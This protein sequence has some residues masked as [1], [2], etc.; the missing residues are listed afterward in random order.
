VGAVGEQDPAQLLQAEPV[1]AGVGDGE[2]FVRGSVV[3]LRRCGVAQ[4]LV[5]RAKAVVLASGVPNVGTQAGDHGF[6][7][8]ST[9]SAGH[10]EQP[11]R[12]T[13]AHGAA[14]VNRTLR[15]ASFAPRSSA[16]KYQ[17]P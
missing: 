3:D 15:Q 9:E 17:F 14:L 5:F 4:N 11:C 2:A 6:G 7:S 12:T 8:A 1:A 16:H 13:A 10:S